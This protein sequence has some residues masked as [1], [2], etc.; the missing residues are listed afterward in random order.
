[1]KFRL[2]NRS[3]DFHWVLVAV[4]GAAQPEFKEAFLTEL[5][6]ACNKENKPILLGGD[7]IIIRNPSEKNNDRFDGRWPFLFKA[8]IDGLD[9]RETEM[10]GRKY[11][12]ANAYAG[13]SGIIPPF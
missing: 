13:K 9:L 3:D 12:W 7:F 8:I 2:R 4:Y 5:V 10:S 6:Q 11:T 1:V